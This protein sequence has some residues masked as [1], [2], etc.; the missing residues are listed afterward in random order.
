MSN[1][2]EISPEEA[3][4]LAKFRDEKAK[5]KTGFVPLAEGKG[6]ATV[7]VGGLPVDKAVF[8]AIRNS[9]KEA[10]DRK[11]FVVAPFIRDFRADQLKKLIELGLSPSKML[12]NGEE[13][14]N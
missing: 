13:E 1:I 7:D 14:V 12:D 4:L 5:A 10:R 3:L 11:K 2:D 8:D 9:L 6:N